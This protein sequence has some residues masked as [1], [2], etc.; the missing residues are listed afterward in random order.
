MDPISAAIAAI[1]VREPGDELS[2]RAAL[3]IFSVNRDTLRRR[4]QGRTRSRAGAAEQRML[5]NP[6]QEIQLVRYIEKL[7]ARSIPP[8]RAI[9]KNYALALAKWEVSV[10]RAGFHVFW[11]ET[12]PSNIEMDKRYGPQPSPG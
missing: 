3:A 6:Q 7:S 4:H 5:L 11:H 12:R 8:T 2:Y 1:D 10:Q 9:I